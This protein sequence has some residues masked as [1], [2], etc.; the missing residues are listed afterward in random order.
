METVKLLQSL[1]FTLHPEKSVLKP[2]QKLTFLGFVLN[3][4]TMTLTLTD[5]KKE[6]IIKSGEGILNRQYIT[7]RE[8][9]QFIGNAVATFEAVL[10]GPLHYRDMKK[11]KITKLRENKGKLDAKFT[12]NE[13]S[14]TEIKW[15]IGNI[16]GCS[17]NLISREVDITIYSDASNTDW[18]G[19]NRVSSINGKWSIEEQDCDINEPE[20]LA[21]KFSLLSCCKDLCNKVIC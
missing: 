13:E 17:R 5:A 19:A 18:G 2:T 15:W 9:A 11:L 3:S 8:L 20:L 7:I 21:I 12:F 4:K 10:T 16:E 6:N 1:R 14:K